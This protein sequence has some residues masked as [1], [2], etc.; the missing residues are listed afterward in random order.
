VLRELTKLH[1]EVK[2]GSLADLR[3]WAATEQPRGEIALV[4]A[5]APPEAASSEDAAA[6]LRTLRRSGLS[7]SQA[8]REAAAITGL[9][10]SE[11]YRIA[12]AL[13]AESSGRLKREF[14]PPQEDAL[15]DALGDEEG[16]E[17]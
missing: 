17:R 9:A 14:A 7:A 3:D 6:V 11:L 2:P 10:R 5:G 13:P 1:E 15:Q 8:A 12:S 4:V 16:P